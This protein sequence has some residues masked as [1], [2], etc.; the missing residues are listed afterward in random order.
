MSMSRMVYSACRTCTAKWFSP[1]RM[2]AC[3]RCGLEEVMHTEAAPPWIPSS[4][5]ERETHGKQKTK[6][7]RSTLMENR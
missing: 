2:P 3:P 5:N 7:R 4:G 1:R 6:S